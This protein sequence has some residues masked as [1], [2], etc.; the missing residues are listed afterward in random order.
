MKL[1]K[2]ICAVGIACFTFMVLWQTKVIAEDPPY[3]SILSRDDQ[4]IYRLLQL[5]FQQD[6]TKRVKDRA[7]I[8]GQLNEIL[9]YIYHDSENAGGRILVC[10]L[11]FIPGYQIIH[12]RIAYNVQSLRFLLG[13]GKSNINGALVDENFGKLSLPCSNTIFEMART[14]DGAIAQ[15][16]AMLKRSNNFGE[17]HKWVIRFS[18]GTF[19]PQLA[20]NSTA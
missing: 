5:K 8:T 17:M 20:Q 15:F 13:R 2:K 1:F 6:A 9:Q 18:F 10:G 16:E 12:N 11:C 3:F 7:S 14:K 19:N 4:A